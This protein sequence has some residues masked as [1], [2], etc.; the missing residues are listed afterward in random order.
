MMRLILVF[1]ILFP[2][3]LFA[4][5]FLEGK[6]LICVYGKNKNIYET[7]LFS[8]DHY[9]ANFLYLEKGTY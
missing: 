8:K 6:G 5:K 7:Y 9:V 1:I 4:N 2:V 3:K